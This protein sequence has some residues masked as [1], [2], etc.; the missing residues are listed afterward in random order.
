MARIAPR[1][2]R[3]RVGERCGTIGHDRSSAQASGRIAGL[4]L[5][6]AAG[7]GPDLA[8]LRGPLA[9]VPGVAIGHEFGPGASTD[10]AACFGAGTP[11]FELVVDG[12]SFDLCGRGCDVESLRAEGEPREVVEALRRHRG[13]RAACLVPGP[14][15]VGAAATLPVVRAMMHL[16]AQIAVAAPEVE[17]LVWPP[18]D[19]SAEPAE[20]ARAIAPW[21]GGGA[22]P[23]P[24]LVQFRPTL[25]GSV[26]S[27][28]LAYFT[29]QE[30]RIEGGMA[31]DPSYAHRLAAR[32]AEMLAHRG[33]LTAAEQF[34]GPSGEQLRL[35][36]SA[37]GRYVRV[38]TG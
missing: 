24:G 2:L 9:A 5:V 32:L 36:P 6:F 18:A 12:L 16:G 28:G 27:A 25:D 33:R 1:P 31:A 19:W 21:S 13:R 7:A 34:A 15:L 17:A 38:R 8:A 35:E 29:G 3:R 14:H 10:R 30:L 22:F 11:L 4:W 23:A 26:Q 37:N 20:F